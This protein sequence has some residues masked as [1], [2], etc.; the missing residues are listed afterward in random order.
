MSSLGESYYYEE[1]CLFVK[2]LCNIGIFF[3]NI[4]WYLG[5]A[6]IWHPYL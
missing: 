6:R 4:P 3:V 2:I 1:H 5:I